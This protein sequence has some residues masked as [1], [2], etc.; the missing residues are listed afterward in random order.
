M[1]FHPKYK[2]LALLDDGTLVWVLP[3]RLDSNGYQSTVMGHI[4]SKRVHRLVW[5]IHNNRTVPTGKVVRHYD[6]DNKNNSIKNLVI[7]TQYDNIQDT[8]RHGRMVYGEKVGTSKL[9]NKQVLEI[10]SRIKDGEPAI[11]LAKEFGVDKVVIRN[12]KSG[13]HWGRIT[14]LKRGI[15]NQHSES[16]FQ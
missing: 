8:K 7:G 1:K 10:Y 6:G 11:D 15:G 12:I 3:I 16:Q 4:G 13:K 14:G 2:R 9:T 5:E